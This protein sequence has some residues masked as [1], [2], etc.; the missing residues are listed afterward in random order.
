M[1]APGGGPEPRL[2][3]LD[4]DPADAIGEGPREDPQRHRVQAELQ[5]RHRQPLPSH[6]E[7]L[8]VEGEMAPPAPRGAGGAGGGAP[9]PA[10][11]G[12]G[13]DPW[14]GADVQ[15]D[16]TLEPSGGRE[17]GQGREQRGTDDPAQRQPSR[18]LAAP[19]P[20]PP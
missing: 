20:P 1:G 17:P 3:R 14:A 19:A 12:G 5:Q 9:P 15:P 13:L 2:A 4:R 11:G 8:D 18:E 6:G 16:G 10:G 7:A